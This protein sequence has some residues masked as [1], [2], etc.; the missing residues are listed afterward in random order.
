METKKN[1]AKAGSVDCYPYGFERG[2]VEAE[3]ADLDRW[4]VFLVETA[5]VFPY[6]NEWRDAL[7]RGAWN[8]MDEK[9]RIIDRSRGLIPL[10]FWE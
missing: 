1:H 4:A 3:V 8:V 2:S 7:Q 6:G 10:W 9:N 5:S